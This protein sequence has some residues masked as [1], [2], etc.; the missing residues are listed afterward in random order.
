MPTWRRQSLI[1]GVAVLWAV[2][3]VWMTMS[4]SG[5]T[6]GLPLLLAI[7]LLPGGLLFVYLMRHRSARILRIRA[8]SGVAGLAAFGQAAHDAPNCNDPFCGV[9]MFSGA[10]VDVGVYVSLLVATSWWTDRG[11]R[12]TAP[13]VPTPAWPAAAGRTA[14]TRRRRNHLR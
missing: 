9:A 3:V 4:S 5:S 12:R 1:L 7:C 8:I 10:M 13:I 11:K 6:N 14:K 2:A